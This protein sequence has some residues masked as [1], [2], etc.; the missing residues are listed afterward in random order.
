MATFATATVTAARRLSPHV[1]EI[2]L[3]PDSGSLNPYLPGQWLSLR[4][5]IGDN[6]PLIRAY[7]LATAPNQDGS[8]VLCFDRVEGGLGS[9]YLWGVEPGTPI[10][11]GGPVGNFVPAEDANP[12]L[13]VASFTGIVP[14]RAMLQQ[15]AN[16]A[17]APVAVRLLYATPEGSERIYEAEFA[18]IADAGAWLDYQSIVGGAP[19][20]VARLVADARG[21]MPFAPMICGVREFT[22]PVRAA[23]METCG[24]D[25]RQIKVENYSGPTAR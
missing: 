16:A 5:P 19:E 22:A 12:L 1:R 3:R 24:F 4:L 15:M 21:W 20:T 14:F 25:R 10:E 9:E 8:L 13:M 17:V 6:P 18:A 23:L 7:S 2:T 11:Y